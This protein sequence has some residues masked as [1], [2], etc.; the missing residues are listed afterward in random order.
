M[1]KIFVS[2]HN[3]II[4][5]YSASDFL[6]RFTLRKSRHHS[7]LSFLLGYYLVSVSPERSRAKQTS[8]Q[9][10]RG[11]YLVSTIAVSMYSTM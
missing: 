11:P 4:F 1:V 7:L 2:T 3:I 6:L 9:T 5:D 8:L 10:V